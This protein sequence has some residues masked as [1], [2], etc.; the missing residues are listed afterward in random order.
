MPTEFVL[1]FFTKPSFVLIFFI[2]TQNFKKKK[3]HC[4]KVKQQKYTIVD[5]FADKKTAL[6]FRRFLR[7][8]IC[9]YV[10]KD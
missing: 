3:K 2:N 1:I 9:Y 10:N 7:F 6:N 8:D 5:T 4:V